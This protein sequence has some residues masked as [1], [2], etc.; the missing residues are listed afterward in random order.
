[1]DQKSL[2]DAQDAGSE[3]QG[4][5]VD[6]GAAA[7][8]AA[9]GGAAGSDD[10][11]GDEDGGHDGSLSEDILALIEDGRTYAEA[12][13]AFQKTRLAY[14]ASSVGRG[15]LFILAAFAFFH[16]ALIGLVVGA[17]FAL[18]PLLT[19]WGAI[20]VVV[21]VLII[22]GCV[23]AVVAKSRFRNMSNSFRKVPK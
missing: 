16:L 22:G 3:T 21:G 6:T 11:G 13:A 9:S 19:M 4:P 10:D 7:L 1:M 18:A 8:G 12:E 14:A 5:H 20:G 23:L 2:P 15:M 17:I